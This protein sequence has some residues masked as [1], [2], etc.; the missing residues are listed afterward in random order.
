MVGFVPS[1]LPP[2]QNIPFSFDTE[3]SSIDEN[4]EEVVETIH[5]SF[6]EVL[7]NL[8]TGL[9]VVPFL[10]MMENMAVVQTFGGFKV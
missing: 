2:F 10:S 1:G 8:G 6:G 3:V 4:G 5:E 9:I 7:S